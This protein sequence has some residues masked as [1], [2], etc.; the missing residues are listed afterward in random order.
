MATIRNQSD[1]DEPTLPTV[2]S[3]SGA[4]DPVRYIS[5]EEHDERIRTNKAAREL[6][7]RYESNRAKGLKE[8]REKKLANKVKEKEAD[9]KRKEDSAKYAKLSYEEMVKEDKRRAAE[10]RSKGEYVRGPK[11][12]N[13]KP[14]SYRNVVK[15][16]A[17]T[18]GDPTE[19]PKKF[20]FKKG[21]IEE[22]RKK[23]GKS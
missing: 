8:I 1:D 17:E 14:H 11:S 4:V 21:A 9:A 15:E 10:R 3:D 7:E 16:P 22:L 5:R 13:P 18:S 23:L 6:K 20:V 19:Q 2:H 12:E